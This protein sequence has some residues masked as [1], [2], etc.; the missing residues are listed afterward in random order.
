[1]HVQDLGVMKLT[2]KT[3]QN[4]RLA[5]PG[6]KYLEQANFRRTCT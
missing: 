5:L 3:Q 2:R 1:M 6:F 4:E